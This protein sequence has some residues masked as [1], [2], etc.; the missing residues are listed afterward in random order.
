[1]ETLHK[2]EQFQRRW[3]SQS[4]RMQKNFLPQQTCETKQEREHYIIPSS[5]PSPV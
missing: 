2:V 5:V 3:F 4:R 1:M